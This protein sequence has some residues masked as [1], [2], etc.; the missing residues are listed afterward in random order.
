MRRR[1]RQVRDNPFNLLLSVELTL[2]VLLAALSFIKNSSSL[3]IALWKP[4]RRGHDDPGGG[5]FLTKPESLNS[6]HC[7]D[8]RGM[9]EIGHFLG[10]AC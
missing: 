1:R 6:I 8:G 7:S 9:L 4:E 5:I 3:R 2:V 10:P